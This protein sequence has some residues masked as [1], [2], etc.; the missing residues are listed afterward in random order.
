VGDTDA[1]VHA[2]AG[3]YRRLVD[4]LAVRAGV[5]GIVNPSGAAEREALQRGLRVVWGEECCSL[6]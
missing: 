6:P 4:V 1:G 5:N 3:T 2:T